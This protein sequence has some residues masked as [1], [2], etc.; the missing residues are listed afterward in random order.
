MKPAPP[1]TRM[2]SRSAKAIAVEAAG[3]GGPLLGPPPEIGGIVRPAQP[4]GGGAELGGVEPAIVEGDLL[5]RHHLDPLAALERPDERSGLVEAVMGSGVEPGEAP[6]EPD[7]LELAEI[8]IGLVDVGD[9]ELAARR[10][11]DPGGDVEHP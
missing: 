10:R 3:A 9:L 11:P 2:V 5:R 4:V 8:E 7:D 6:A 1:V